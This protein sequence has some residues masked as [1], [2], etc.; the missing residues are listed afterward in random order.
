MAAPYQLRCQIFGHEKD[1]RA[2]T[3][4]LIP[5][6][7][8]ISGSRDATAR[9]WVP[10]EDSNG[11]REGHFM[12]GHKNF[13]ASVCCLPPDD[14]Y[15]HGLIFTG[16]NDHTIL[17]FTPDSPQ[18]VFKL[19]GHTGTVCSLAGGKF[20]TLLSGSWDKTAK[21]WINQKCVLT[22]EGHES[23]VWA[24]AIMPD[25]GVMLTGSADKTIKVWKA[26][27]CENTL[28]GHDDCVRDLAVTQGGEFLS[29]SN[30]ATVRRWLVSGDCIA[31]YYGH[32]NFVYSLAVLPNG[33]DFVSS[34]ED[35]T[36][37]V[38]K[39]GTC[40]QTINHPCLSIW[41]VAVLGNGDI[42]SG[43]S[44]G[45]LRV[46]T[47]EPSRYAS[48]VELKTYDEQI[49]QSQIP[50]DIR[51]E[52]LPGPEALTRPGNKEGQ[53]KMVRN[54]AGKVELY[55][56][57]GAS[58]EWKKVGDVVGSSG[59][60]QATSGKTLYEG[61]EYDYVFTVD[62]QEGQPPLKLPYN[63]SEDPWF[64][65][66]AFIQKNNLSQ[67]FLDQVANFITE[68]TKGAT[69]AQGAPADFADPF[70]GGNRYMPGSSSSTGVVNG[71]DPFT[72]GGRYIPGSGSGVGSTGGGADPFTGSGRYVPTYTDTTRPAQTGGGGGDV[73]EGA[74]T[75]TSVNPNLSK[76]NEYF[77]KMTTLT[78][79]VANPAQIM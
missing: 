3:P 11:F 66:Q 26:G 5:D 56:W 44:D 37:R 73:F 10:E 55:S 46:F 13:V 53:T 45:I 47:C 27:K 43:A 34:G 65:A 71:A 16:S 67:L 60:T 19:T 14:K 9:I 69:L 57:D 32:E 50:Q 1:V 58:S 49:A 4:A 7:S 24:V 21:V 62:I 54:A 15:P 52:E 51:P 6:N 35:R 33:H 18:A 25:L 8:V 78:F 23:A 61:K 79:D 64:A 22:L 40:V 39:D 30:D 72:G 31:V 68:N 63:I 41:C 75:T 38:W 76:T 70:T 48:T 28:R 74:Y 77:P 36:V 42:V 17:A 59:G 2:V 20:G 12:S 29:C